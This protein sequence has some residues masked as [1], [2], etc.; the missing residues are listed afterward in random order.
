MVE[1]RTNRRPNTEIKRR[2]VLFAIMKQ[3]KL[4]RSILQMEKKTGQYDCFT[5]MLQAKSRR[6]VFFA[7]SMETSI[8]DLLGSIRG[9]L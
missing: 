2:I 7:F 4:K 5:D 6:K 1:F 3:Q 8:N 9:I